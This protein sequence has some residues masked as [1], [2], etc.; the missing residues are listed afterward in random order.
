MGVLELDLAKCHGGA[1]LEEEAV[2]TAVS[3][4]LGG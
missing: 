1:I 4:Y 2:L 3:T